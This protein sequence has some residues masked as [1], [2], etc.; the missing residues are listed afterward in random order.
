MENILELLG[1]L[2]FMFLVLAASVEVILELF[3]GSLEFFGF[4]WQRGKISLDDSLKLA[5]EFSIDSKELNT[6]VQ[7]VM[8]AAKQIEKKVKEKIEN[9]DNLKESLSKSGVDFGEISAELDEIAVGIREE[10]QHSERLR[11]A[12]LRAIAA[13]L[14]CFLVWMSEFYVFQ[15]LVQ[16]GDIKN[17]SNIL[18]GLQAEWINIL[19]G[20]FAAAAGSA[21]WHDKLDKIRNLKAA[22]QEM[23][24]LLA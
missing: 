10:L 16:S 15:I 6:K 11:M 5:K 17:W 24:K 9:L 21:Y 20:G 23:Q 18:Q 2:F 1:F 4:T 13:A 22:K 8:S 7:A 14:G 19:V 3:R 12:I